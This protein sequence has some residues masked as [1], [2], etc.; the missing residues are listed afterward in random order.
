MINFEKILDEDEVIIKEY[1]PNKKKFYITSILI[2][3]IVAV[4]MTVGPFIGFLVDDEIR[5][6]FIIIPIGIVVFLLIL[7]LLFTK[8]AYNKRLY[9]YT[10]KRVLIQGGIIGIDY[11]SLDLEFIGASEVKVDLL[12]KMLGNNTGTIRFGS[13]ATPA[14]AQGG[15]QTFVFN[16]IEDPYVVYKEIKKHIDEHKKLI[17]K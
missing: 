16:S 10:N 6:I 8:M 4:F 5:N 3:F 13:Q 17:N 12:D 1:K 15:I 7:V 14:A 9:A 11:K 2:T